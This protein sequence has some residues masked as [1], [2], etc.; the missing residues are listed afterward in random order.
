MNNQ[1]SKTHLQN[2]LPSYETKTKEKKSDIRGLHTV[3]HA[4]DN[5]E[6]KSPLLCITKWG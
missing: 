3:P 6:S 1:V 5:L 4:T 2:K